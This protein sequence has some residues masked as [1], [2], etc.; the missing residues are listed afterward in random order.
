MLPLLLDK[1]SLD[2]KGSS[3]SDADLLHDGQVPLA[4]Q[5][6]LHYLHADTFYLRA[7]SL[8][9]LDLHKDKPWC[10]LVDEACSVLSGSLQSQGHST[11]L[12]RQTLGWEDPGV[13]QVSGWP[14]RHCA[15]R[16][17]PHWSDVPLQLFQLPWRIEPSFK[18]RAWLQ[19]RNNRFTKPK[20]PL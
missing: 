19:P 4:E 16:C 8:H 6:S 17:L 15:D 3:W 7:Q 20:Q 5:S 12:L 18:S 14:Q 2:Q 11:E 10:L 9:W 1:C 13:L